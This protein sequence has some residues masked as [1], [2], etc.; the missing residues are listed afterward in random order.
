MLFRS[1]VL[2]LSINKLVRNTSRGQSSWIDSTIA[3]PSQEVEF[4]IQVTNIGNTDLSNVRVWDA[5]PVH[6][7]YVSGSTYLDNSS[8]GSV[9]DDGIIIGTLNKNQTKEIRF[10]AL[11]AA[12]SSFGI[13]TTTL[14]NTGYAKTDNISQVSDQA[15][16]VVPRGEVKGATT[17]ITG[18]SSFGFIFLAIIS[19]FLAFFVYCSTREAKLLEILNNKGNK[20]FK[21]LI[22]FYFRIKFF[23]TVTKLRFKKVYW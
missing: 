16:V 6:L 1:E 5:L 12:S 20:L 10:K 13:G 4:L 3:S 18:V 7:S 21:G 19:V 23:V 15:S 17:I 22:K 2:E 11:V 14:F 9:L 8:T